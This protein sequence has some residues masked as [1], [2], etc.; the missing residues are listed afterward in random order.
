MFTCWLSVVTFPWRLSFFQR[1]AILQ[2]KHSN[3]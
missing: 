2:H 1:C 3:P